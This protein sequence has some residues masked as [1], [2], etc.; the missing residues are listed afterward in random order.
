TAQY[1][2]TILEESEDAGQEYIDE[3][4]FLGDSNTVGMRQ[5]GYC[6]ES[7]SLAS[8]GM[9]ARSLATYECVLFEGRSSYVTMPEAV[10]I[11][12]P[13]RVILTF[14]TNDLSPSYSTEKF[15]ENYEEG[16]LAIVE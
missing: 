3:T 15:I 12:Q 10:A 13:Q 4:L 14:G 5:F 8:V 9:S 2:S 6:E 1:A 16:I 7:N 11:M